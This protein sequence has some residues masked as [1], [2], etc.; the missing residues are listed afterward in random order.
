M[1]CLNWM[2]SCLI[3]LQNH[4]HLANI[5]FLLLFEDCLIQYSRPYCYH[6]DFRH[7]YKFRECHHFGY[8]HELRD[9][10]LLFS[11][12]DERWEKESLGSLYTRLTRPEKLL[13][14][15]KINRDFDD[16]RTTQ[17]IEFWKTPTLWK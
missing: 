10:H 11:P 2:I 8:R 17:L 1:N 9:N 6:H 3:V 5:I 15:K 7:H 16:K 14:I 4:L 13:I 12:V